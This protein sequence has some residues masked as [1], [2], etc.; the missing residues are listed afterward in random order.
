[1][2]NWALGVVPLYPD[3]RVM[4]VGQHRY[5]L[6]EYSW[7]I[8]EGGGRIGYDALDE[9]K[10]EL[11]EETGL[12][13]SKWSPLGPI[14]TSNSVVDETGYLWLA[15]DLTEG[16]GYIAKKNFEPLKLILTE[17]KY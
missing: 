16:K 2:K 5:P 3:G 15:E 13:A 14:H 17:M 1:M 7:E 8:P 6:N 10:R 11:L 4:L 9:I 12:F